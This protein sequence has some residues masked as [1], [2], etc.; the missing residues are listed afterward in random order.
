M[1]RSSYDRRSN[2][3]PDTDRRAEVG[4]SFPE[5]APTTTKQGAAMTTTERGSDVG[6][7]GE[8]ADVNGIS[9]YYETHGSGRPL[10]LLHG[11]LGS[12]E[13]FG[14]ILPALADRPPGHRP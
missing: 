11:G 13:M 7:T 14:P 1:D 8:Y 6:G 3:E 2:R 10:I 4:W 12:G 9:L 5:I